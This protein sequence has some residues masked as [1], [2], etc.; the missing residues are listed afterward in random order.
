MNPNFEATTNSDGVQSS[1]PFE[2]SIQPLD[3][4]AP[5]VDHLPFGC[6]VNPPHKPLVP[7]IGEDDGLGRVLPPNDIIEFAARVGWVSD[8]MLR[9]EWDSCVHSRVARL[10]QQR[11][12][13]VDVV[14]VTRADVDRDGQLVLRVR[15]NVNLETPCILHFPLGVRLHDPSRIWVSVLPALP[16][17]PTI[18]P[19]LNRRTVYGNGLAEVRKGVEQTTGESPHDVLDFKY[20]IGLCQLGAKTGERWLARDAIRR[21][22]AAGVGDEWVI[23]EYADEGRDRCEAQVVVGYVA[24]PENFGVVS[25]SATPRW[26][27]ELS[28][29]F[30]IGEFRE[31]C[32]KLGD[33]WWCLSIPTE[34]FIMGTTHREDSTFLVDRGHLASQA[35]RGPV[36][37][38]KLVYHAMLR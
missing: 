7:D 14:D 18:R 2:P 29:E 27:C 21:I 8:D 33:Y 36:P 19:R 24:M 34:Y 15:Q 20:E 38:L 16:L 12:G 5:V 30:F 26:T 11:C 23:V 17:L 31:D 37:L 1:M 22:D 35:P 32:L 9:I 6:L 10:R 13:L 28:Q 4:R 25:W 3:A